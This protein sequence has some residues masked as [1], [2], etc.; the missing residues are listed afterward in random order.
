MAVE[1]DKELVPSASRIN[2]Y[3]ISPFEMKPDA[4][5]NG[6][7][8]LPSI[9]K[10]EDDFRNPTVGQ[11]EPII[12][13]KVDGYP[14]IVDGVGRWR[15]ACNISNAKEGPHEGGVFKLQC[16]YFV[17]KS[18]LD[19][20]IATVKANIRNETKP[21]DDAHN[22]SIFLHN[23][24]LSEED[25]AGRIYGRFTA[26]GKPDVKW[27]RD[28]AALSNL[29]AEGL[30]ALKAGTLKPKSA[31]AL[32]GMTAKI[33]KEKLK[34]LA[35][36]EKLTVAAIKRKD[37]TAPSDRKH[38]KMKLSDWTE[39]WTPYADR[40]DSTMKRLADAFLTST[41]SGDP[42]SFF[43]ALTQELKRAERAA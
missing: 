5:L 42:D 20:F 8:D 41:A 37:D 13:K 43:K 14:V 2:I 11:L 9:K 29:T 15:A 12:I 4:D 19:Y 31:I 16:R 10:F 25:I 27:V 30:E 17:A 40:A 32:A 24:N 22:V 33:Q 34:K 3:L 23:F 7:V 18:P 6:R 21:A 28:M 36:G 35:A 1:F 38:G 26:D 39:F